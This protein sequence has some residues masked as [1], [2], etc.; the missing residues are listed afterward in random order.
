MVWIAS[1]TSGSAFSYGTFTSIPQTF[2]HL[3]LRVFARATFNNGGYNGSVYLTFNG[4]GTSDYGYRHSLKGNGATASSINGTSTGEIFL[5]DLIA[6]GGSITSNYGAG[7]IDILDYTNTNK[8]K[9]IRAIGGADNNGAA[10]Y[11]AATFN[12]QAWLNTAAINAIQVRTDSQFAANSRIDLYGI[13]S[14]QVTGA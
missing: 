3:Q 8:N 10:N 13:T 1:A 2:T 7:I 14:S 9:T 4:G 12:S 11:G 6:D 5:T